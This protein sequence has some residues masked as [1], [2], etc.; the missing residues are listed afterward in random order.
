MYCIVLYCI[1][2][3][4]YTFVTEKTSKKGT[5]DPEGAR[6]LTYAYGNLRA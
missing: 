4:C 3:Y 5:M 6:L 1:V 2:L